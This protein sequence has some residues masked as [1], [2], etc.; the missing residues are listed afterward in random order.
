MKLERI[1]AER[2]RH[3]QAEQRKYNYPFIAYC[4]KDMIDELKLVF[5]AA[6]PDHDE[7]VEQADRVDHKDHNPLENE[8]QSSEPQ[9][10]KEPCAT[11]SPVE[12]D[13]MI[14]VYGTCDKYRSRP[15]HVLHEIVKA[16]QYLLISEDTEIDT[17]SELACGATFMPKTDAERDAIRKYVNAFLNGLTT[18]IIE[19]A[20]GMRATVEL[21][22][23][24]GC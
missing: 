4:A 19:Q 3:Y 17:L 22:K 7:R 12:C 6:Q 15:M 2:I 10:K 23:A 20:A 11:C 1:I 21:S 9:T 8:I 13:G 16:L 18:Q 24:L 14:H 5:N